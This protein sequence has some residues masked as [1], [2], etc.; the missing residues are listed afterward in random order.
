M[1]EKFNAIFAEDSKRYKIFK[2]AV[3]A[4][5]IK[6]SIKY[7]EKYKKHNIL[8]F[9]AADPNAKEES[10]CGGVEEPIDVKN[11]NFN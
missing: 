11:K 1:E 6:L 7:T 3:K 8:I 9:V 2:K 4:G 5:D 10:S